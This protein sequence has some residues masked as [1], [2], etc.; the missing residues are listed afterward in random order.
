MYLD[1]V[2][3]TVFWTIVVSMCSGCTWKLPVLCKNVLFSNSWSWKSWSSWKVHQSFAV[4]H[5]KKA[6]RA[7]QPHVFHSVSSRKALDDSF[8]ACVIRSLVSLSADW[9]PATALWNSTSQSVWNLSFVVNDSNIW[10][11]S[12]AP[13]VKGNR[14]NCGYADKVRGRAKSLKRTQLFSL[15]SYKPCVS[16]QLHGAFWAKTIWSGHCQVLFSVWVCVSSVWSSG[17]WSSSA[18]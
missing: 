11:Q 17:L 4:F 15:Q 9:G 18:L 5:K 13:N 16:F 3:V 7:A 2:I 14:A 10:G 6:E 12:S 1:V 8:P